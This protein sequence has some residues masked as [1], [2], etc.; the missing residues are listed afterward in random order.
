[1][2]QETPA[3]KIIDATDQNPPDAATLATAQRDLLARLASASVTDAVSLMIRSER[4]RYYAMADLEWLLLPALALGQ[5]MFAYQRPQ[6]AAAKP[7]GDG[8]QDGEA[9]P[10]PTAP[11]LA[12]AMLTWALVLPEVGAKI[13]AQKKA[14]VPVRLAPQ[15][16]RSGKELRIVEAIGVAK[17]IAALTA[18]VHRHLQQTA[19]GKDAVA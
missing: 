19:V 12:T 5:I 9:A 14:G 4:H 15:E 18:K 1:M 16:W 17:D 3:F 8:V 6:L 10:A 11:P 13:D 2:T 7:A